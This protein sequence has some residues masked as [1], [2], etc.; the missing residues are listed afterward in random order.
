MIFDTP[1]RVRSL[2]QGPRIPPE[3]R[4]VHRAGGLPQAVRKIAIMIQAQQEL[5]AALAEALEETVPGHGLVPA[6]ESP[7]QASHGDLAITA[8]MP[9][10]K[11]VRSAPRELAQKLVAAL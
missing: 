6:F 10:A 1:R 8:A 4:F 3:L 11:Q 7:K 9:L 5:L 2:E